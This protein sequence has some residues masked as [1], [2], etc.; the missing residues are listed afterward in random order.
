MVLQRFAR[1]DQ[2]TIAVEMSQNGVKKTLRGTGSYERD[3]DLGSVLTITVSE[4]WG[5]FAVVLREDEFE[6]EIT[7]GSTAGCD[8]AICLSATCACR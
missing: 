7:S 2:A 5:D 3:P 1:L 6:G 8:Y 4:K